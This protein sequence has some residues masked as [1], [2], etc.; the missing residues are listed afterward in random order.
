MLRKLLIVS[1]LPLY[2][3]LST[4]FSLHMHYCHGELKSI[5]LSYSQSCC[6]EN[7]CNMGEGKKCAGCLN[8]ELIIEPVHFEQTKTFSG[9]YK[10]LLPQYVISS[11]LISIDSGISIQ[12]TSSAVL[13]R[14]PPLVE[15]FYLAHHQLTYYG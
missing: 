9:D 13:S 6:S 7:T 11:Y 3:I 2:I 14:P 8:E 5:S 15:K 1:I 4:G 12:N 10:I